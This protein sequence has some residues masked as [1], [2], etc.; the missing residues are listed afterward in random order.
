MIGLPRRIALV[1]VLA[2]ALIV[3]PGTAAV[4]SEPAPH[5]ITKLAIRTGS[6]DEATI[7][8]RVNQARL[9]ACLP[10]VRRN[11]AMDTVARNWSKSMSTSGNFRHNPNF[12]SQIPRGWSWAAENIAAGQS[13]GSTMMTAWMKSSGHKANILNPRATDV[14]IGFIRNT[15]AKYPTWGT[16]VFAQYSRK[17]AAFLDVPSWHKF[18]TEIEW[19]DD[20]GL[21]SGWRCGSEAQF[22]PSMHATREAMAVFLYRYAGSPSFT[23]PSRSPFTDVPTSHLHYKQ[24]TWMAARG[25]TTG[26]TASNGTKQFKPGTALNRKIMSQFL[27]RFAGSPNISTPSR[28]P[29]TD[30]KPSSAYYDAVMWVRQEGLSRGWTT[31]SGSVFRPNSTTNRETL[32]TFLYRLSR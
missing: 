24:I 11:S 3:P 7:L 20:R 2:V 1:S 26:Y 19:A 6:A 5:G 28:S 10:V 4:A 22:R 8:Q 30:L 32:T 18:F 16:Q 31:S 29:Y 23:P 12:S 9:N 27:Y 13:N 17:N 21:T 15:S 14:G 25:I